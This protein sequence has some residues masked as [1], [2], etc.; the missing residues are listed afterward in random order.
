MGRLRSILTRRLHRWLALAVLLDALV[1]CSIEG[2]DGDGDTLD[3]TLAGRNGVA[4]EGSLANPFATTED[5]ATDRARKRDRGSLQG[6]FAGNDPA[7]AL[8]SVGPVDRL[9][10]ARAL[11]DGETAHSNIA[12][13]PTSTAP[14]S[15]ISPKT[16]YTD[17]DLP[18]RPAPDEYSDMWLIARVNGVTD[19]NPSLL[20][21]HKNGRLFA[22][23]EV[24]EHW[25]LK[26]P[27][28]EVTVFKG[29]P[30]LPLDAID[31]LAYMVD[32]ATQELDVE[33][34]PH[35]FASTV[36]GPAAQEYMP[37]GPRTPGG[38]FNYDLQYLNQDEQSSVDGLFELGFFNR[39][40]VG[41]SS[42]LGRELDGDA[43][44][45]RLETTWTYDWPEQMW[46]ARLGDTINRPGAWGRPVRFG[47]VQWGTNFATRPDYIPFPLP[48][49]AGEAAL[50][51]S[52]DVF[53]E[54]ARRLG[55]EVPAGPFSIP[56]LPVVTG[57]G[58]VTVVV[59]DLLGREQVITQPYYVS[60][61]LLRDGLHDYSYEL[62]LVRE[63]F[64]L[65]SNDYGRLFGGGT[66][67]MGFSDRFT[68]EVRGELIED[69]QTAGVGG[70]F[71]WPTIGTANLAVATSQ[72][73]GDAGGLISFGFERL[74]RGLSYGL[75]NELTTDRFTQLGLQA[76]EPAPLRTTTAR[77]G[78]PVT[79]RDA[80]SLSYLGQD[81]RD[82]ED[83]EFLAASYGIGLPHDFY[84]SAFALKDMG[85]GSGDSIGMILTKPLGELTTA[86]ASLFRQDNRT[87]AELQVQRNLPP[88]SGAGY[89]LIAGAGENSRDSAG[90]FL[91]N[92]VGTYTAEAARFQGSNAYRLGARGGMA[93]MGGRPFLS[94]WLDDSFGVVKVADYPNVQVY[95]ENQ[96]VARTGADGMAL[97]PRLRS[98]QDNNISI[99]HGDLPLDA[100]IHAVRLDAVPAF[101]SGVLID[102][103]VR[104]ARGALLTIVREDGSP[105]P[106]GAVV[107]RVGD[108]QEFP[109]ALRGE[110]YVT[111]LEAHNKL[112]V[113]WNDQACLIEVD[114][115][116]VGD[117]LPRL[118][119]LVCGSSKLA[120]RAASAR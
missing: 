95:A 16:K 31:G 75:Q 66:H 2:G 1:L 17:L 98:F 71:L 58:D 113:V 55:G 43:D 120:Q 18:G 34:K 44:L 56:N 69:Q 12:S 72:R 41:T 11:P 118:G 4:R 87:S 49:V 30:Y 61:A 99:E 23:R 93:V 89:R 38:F 77:I 92:G 96:P 94:R 119:P 100:Q 63:N 67:R 85:G 104:S 79:G 90:L 88:G 52:V 86:S 47:G 7:D 76:G 22:P 20:L 116:N 91:Q 83:A 107:T 109:V 81:N 82:R 70:T 40:G 60:Q 9:A 65:Q 6:P 78:F 97:V 80:L 15:S 106:A 24:F 108:T 111:G 42:F 36:I 54:N 37:P 29:Q 5:A 105:L 8:K 50:P 19:K 101:R 115:P 14:A 84:L 110:V 32:A 68:G 13:P 114:M 28:A 35:V 102:F 74:T 103:P 117:P 64:G 73:D 59:R 112:Q 33:A 51:S 21:R 53:S 10:A 25:R 57:A 46:T 45:I 3:L 48:A 62:G 26:P 39:F 27:E